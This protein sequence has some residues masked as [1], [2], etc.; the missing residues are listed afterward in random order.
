MKIIDMDA[1]NLK[2]EMSERDFFIVYMSYLGI[3]DDVENFADFVGFTI[4]QLRDIERRLTAIH[5]E[6]WDK[7][8]S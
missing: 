6:F 3:M 1:E 7:I 5:Q 4:A 2:I 8:H